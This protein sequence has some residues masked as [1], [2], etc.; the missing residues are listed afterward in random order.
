MLKAKIRISKEYTLDSHF[1]LSALSTSTS[2]HRAAIR[3]GLIDSMGTQPLALLNP[4]PPHTHTEQSLYLHQPLS[5]LISSHAEHATFSQ[6]VSTDNLFTQ[7]R[8]QG[9]QDNLEA[10][11]FKIVPLQLGCLKIRTKP[12]LQ[13]RKSEMLTKNGTYNYS[14][15]K[16]VT[17]TTI[18]QQC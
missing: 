14:T 11:C 13:S 15:P 5:R 3:W 12:Y 8:S 16:S 9:A 17:D 18:L 1:T 10:V 6:S 2:A 4:P 7:T